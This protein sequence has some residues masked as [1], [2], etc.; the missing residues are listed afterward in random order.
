M[1]GK[2]NLKHLHF[3]WFPEIIQ[4]FKVHEQYKERARIVT[5][6]S[7][8]VTYCELTSHII[9]LFEDLVAPQF[10]NSYSSS[11]L[12]NPKLD[13]GNRK[14]MNPA[15]SLKPFTNRVIIL[16]RH[17]GYNTVITH[18][19]RGLFSKT[20]LEKRKSSKN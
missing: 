6:C 18:F 11:L 7:Y 13:A 8:F 12:R 9:A 1:K 5:M 4:E 19:S 10:V 20:P 17:I 3:Q 16:S 2:A 15:L 14:F